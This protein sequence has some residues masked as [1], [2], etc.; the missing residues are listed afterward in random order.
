[1]EMTKTEFYNNAINVRKHTG[2][3]LSRNIFKI[4]PFFSEVELIVDELVKEGKMK[5]VEITF[6]DL[7][8][9]KWWCLTEG[10]CVEEYLTDGDLTPL[11]FVRHFL[12]LDG[13]PDAF[14]GDGKPMKEVINGDEI[15]SKKYAEWL[16]DNKEVLD[17]ILNITP[18]DDSICVK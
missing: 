1:M 15:K 2:Q 9:E 5:I 7:I 8:D 18:M 12:N 11:T 13:E 14:I 6:G 3:G 10:Y 4:S 17:I 16:V